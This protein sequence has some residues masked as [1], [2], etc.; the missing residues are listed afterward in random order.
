M[1]DSAIA[2]YS[3]E[4]QQRS[5]VTDDETKR[6]PCRERHHQPRGAPAVEEVGVGQFRPND[7]FEITC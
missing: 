2:A 3:I 7:R 6:A 1:H 5:D 4:Q